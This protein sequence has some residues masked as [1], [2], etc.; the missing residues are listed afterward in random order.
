MNP[1]KKGRDSRNSFRL[2]RPNLN[3]RPLLPPGLPGRAVWRND[4]G[5]TPWICFQLASTNFATPSDIGT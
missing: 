4:Y 5:V 3:S 2:S 1:V